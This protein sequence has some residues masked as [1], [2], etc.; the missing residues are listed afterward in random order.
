[1]KLAKPT[2]RTPLLLSVID[3]RR[4]LVAGAISLII[5]LTMTFSIAAA[6]W[7]G[8]IARDNVLEQHARRLSL[9]TD[10]LGSDMSVTIAS[11]LGAVRT[12]GAVLRA[13]QR[14][15][16]ARGLRDVFEELV[17]AYPQLEWVAVADREGRVVDA[18]D[19]SLIGTP[20]NT[21]PWFET[22]IKRPWIGVIGHFTQPTGT[23]LSISL[24]DT[25]ALGDIAVPI[26]DSGGQIAGV[27]AA[28]LTLQRTPDHPQRLTDE[29]NARWTTQAYVLDRAGLVL[30][31]PDD[32]RGSPW[33]A[34][35]L[36]EQ[37]P[38]ASKAAPTH[39]FA[40]GPLFERLQGGSVALVSRTAL[41]LGPEWASLGLQVQLSEPR[42]RV[43]QRANAVAAQILWV[44]IGLGVATAGLGAIGALHLTRRL[45]RLTLSVASIGRTPHAKI[46]V[47]AGQDE[48]AQLGAAF[49]KLIDE[50]DEERGEL[51]TL[52]AELER[53]VAVRTREVERLADESRYAAIVRERLKMARD[54]HDTLAHSLMAILSEIRFIR[55]LPNHNQEFLENELARAEELAHAGLRDAR[56]AITQMRVKTVR[57]TG[58]GPSVSDALNRFT[59]HTGVIG[60]LH[61]DPAAAGFGDERAETLLRMVQEALRNVERHASASRVTIALHTAQEGTLELRI[62]DDGVGF[63]PTSI[64]EG[65]YGLVG[66][67]EQ[68]ELI[69]AQLSID[70]K[71]NEGT[72]VSI[73]LPMSPM[74]F[75]QAG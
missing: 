31:G 58:L 2:R 14:T 35:P 45:K 40:N 61:I 57:E 75:S 15:G 51:K 48:V 16:Q 44:S 50:L 65:H 1:M 70:S 7:V 55:R 43:Y 11:H 56:S 26:E 72:S 68:A 41:N 73:I 3:P 60:E 12:A 52:S 30:I 17:Y 53:R 5:G 33:R 59:D 18:H 24:Q 69:G 29:V 42:E 49:S 21:Q 39:T 64:P 47:P 71:A 10:Q 63:D 46:D 36:K 67:R 23:G 22:G 37:G 20:V 25:M 34:E 13:A 8:R 27:I 19:V 4:S 32:V 74:S 66:L 9:E 6:I 54:L 28:H 38:L 62:K